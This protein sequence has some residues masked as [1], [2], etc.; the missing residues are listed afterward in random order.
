MICYEEEL[1]TYNFVSFNL[2][3]CEDPQLYASQPIW[4]WQQTDMGKWV[5]KHCPDPQFRIITEPQSWGYKCVV[6]GPLTN[7]DAFYFK[8]KFD[9]AKT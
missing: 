9:C 1:Q 4:E 3:D 2:G 5:M 8:L 6:Y 7:K